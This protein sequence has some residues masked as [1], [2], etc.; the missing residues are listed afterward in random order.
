MIRTPCPT[1]HGEGR[2]REQREIEVEVPPGVTS[3][4]YITLRGRGNTGPRGGRPGD[5][6]VLLEIEEDERFTRDGK[7]LVFDLIVTFGQAALGA[8]VE[9]PTVDDS[10]RIEVPAGIQSGQAIR[11]K[12]EGIPDLQGGRRGDLVVRV[13]VWTPTELS[14]EQR[15]MLEKLSAVEDPAPER[16]DEAKMGGRGFWSRVREAFSSG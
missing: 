16:V 8:E 10:T 6:V 1:C 3:E 12:G 4:N 14:A 11:V 13:R 9:V 7:N 2:V 15:E 5:V